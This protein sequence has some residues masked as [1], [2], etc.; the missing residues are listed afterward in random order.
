MSS[1]KGRERGRG[2]KRKQR[3]IRDFILLNQR[4]ASFSGPSAASVQSFALLAV[5]FT[6]HAAKFPPTQS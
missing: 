4:W 5:Y 6:V 1:C 2:K 3:R